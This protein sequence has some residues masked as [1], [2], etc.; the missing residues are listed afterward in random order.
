MPRTLRPRPDTNTLA[1][2]RKRALSDAPPPATRPETCA[3]NASRANASEIAGLFTVSGIFTAAVNKGP[4]VNKA[5]AFH[6]KAMRILRDIPG[7]TVDPKPARGHR[8]VDV[9][10]SFAGTKAQVAIE[11]KSR[12]N[13]A[14]AWQL[15]RY[16]SEVPDRPLLLVAEETT[17]EAR[18]ILHAHGIAVVDGFGNAH[19]ELPGLL[20]HLQGDKRPPRREPPARLSGKAGIIAQTLLLDPKRPWQISDV[21]KR[22]RVSPALAHR[23]MA[24]LDREGL[25]TVEGAGP[26]RIRRV[27]N[28]S[29][30]LDLWAEEDRPAARRTSAHLLAR[31]PEHLLTK[32]SENLGDSDVNYAITG[33]GAA[34]L[35]A[36]FVTAVPVFDVWIGAATDPSWF[37]KAAGAEGVDA[38]QNVVLLQAKHDN[39]LAFRK[40]VDNVWVANRF[41]VYADLLT[42]PRRG[43][44][45]AR[46][47]RDEVIRF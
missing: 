34:S 19:I 11:F 45:Q 20:L 37:L 46:H 31:S 39:P 10:V 3:T 29:A 21:A 22:S 17:A 28:A 23:V 12:A 2:L 30:L 18:A 43:A 13:A 27:A 24:R 44:E 9:F 4:S 38:G 41:R 15:V 6:G 1:Y 33:A 36:P 40:N 32:L 16:A 26:Q 5:E 35:L 14:A 8:G 7:I 47:L 25:T 42:D